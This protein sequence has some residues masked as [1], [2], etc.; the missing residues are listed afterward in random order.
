MHRPGK[1]LHLYP[2]FT[3]LQTMF[4]LS[5][6]VQWWWLVADLLVYVANGKSYKLASVSWPL[7]PAPCTQPTPVTGNNKH[8]DIQGSLSYIMKQD[9]IKYFNVQSIVCLK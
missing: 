4:R 2:V 8:V 1:Q 5:F 9:E 6:P 3:G 7:S